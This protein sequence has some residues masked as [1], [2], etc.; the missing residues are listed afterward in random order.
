MAEINRKIC[1]RNL[2]YIKDRYKLKNCAEEDTFNQAISDM[3][4]MEKIKKI[5]AT[6]GRTVSDKVFNPKLVCEQIEQI[7]KE[8]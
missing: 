3:E 6:C 8:V 7:V 5:F 1:I 4:K 2:K